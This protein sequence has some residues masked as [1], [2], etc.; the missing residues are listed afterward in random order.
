MDF[1]WVL[2]WIIGFEDE[3]K[4]IARGHFNSRRVYSSKTSLAGGLRSYLRAQRAPLIV[5]C[6]LNPLSLSLARTLTASVGP[7][8]RVGSFYNRIYICTG[9]T[10]KRT[11]RGEKIGTL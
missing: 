11:R 1:S 4:P 3:L 10:T 9:G 6:F 5:N 7:S 8:K 2:A